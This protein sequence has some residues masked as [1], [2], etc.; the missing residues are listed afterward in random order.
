LVV[1]GE[2]R[3]PALVDDRRVQVLDVAVACFT[4][5]SGELGARQTR[6]RA[7]RPQTNVIIVTCA[8]QGLGV[9]ADSDVANESR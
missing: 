6:I 4:E 9:L 1:A 7:G 3:P 5:T 8:P 2:G